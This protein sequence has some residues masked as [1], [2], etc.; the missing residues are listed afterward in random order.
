[1]T[2][3]TIQ[4]VTQKGLE[5][6]QAELVD[7]KDNKIPEIA[8]KIDDAKQLGDLSENAEYHAAKEEMGWIQRRAIELQYILDNTQVITKGKDNGIVDL[9]STVKFVTNTGK[10]KEYTIVGPQE[11]DPLSGKISNESPIGKSFLG[12]KSGEKIKVETPAGITQYTIIEIK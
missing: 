7:I 12:A 2:E 9:G 3:D 11:A 10:E 4:Y 8:K 5:D 6:L 1:M